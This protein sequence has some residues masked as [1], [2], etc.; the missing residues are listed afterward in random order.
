MTYSIV[1]ITRTIHERVLSADALSFVAIATCVLATTHAAWSLTGIYEA[2]GPHELAIIGA[3]AYLGLGTLVVERR[4]YDSWTS[5]VHYA[6]AVTAGQLTAAIV[7]VSVMGGRFPMA[8]SAARSAR[9]TRQII[10]KND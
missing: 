4:L 2:R 3:V 6:I 9:H 10:F 7:V 8:R 5:A 1:P